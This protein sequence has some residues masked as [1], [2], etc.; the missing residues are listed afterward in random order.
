VRPAPSA[1]QPTT[2]ADYAARAQAIRSARIAA[3]ADE[4]G[5]A[6]DRSL[7][8]HGAPPRPVSEVPIRFMRKPD[9]GAVAAK[10]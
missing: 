9:S 8:A 7:V 4:G 3:L 2:A 6:L 1:C 5:I 10:S